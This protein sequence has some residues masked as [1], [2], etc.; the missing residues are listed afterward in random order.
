MEIRCK[1]LVLRFSDAFERL[2]KEQSPTEPGFTVGAWINEL[3]DSSRPP[4][5]PSPRE[6]LRSIPPPNSKGSTAFRRRYDLR[7]R[8][9]SGVRES[10]V[11]KS[12]SIQHSMNA[13]TPGSPV[14]RGRPRGRPRGRSRRDAPAG[15]RG[16]SSKTPTSSVVDVPPALVLRPTPTLIPLLQNDHLPDPQREAKLAFMTPAIRFLRHAEATEYGALP[17][18]VQ[19]LWADHMVPNLNRSDCIPD[20]LKD[21]FNTL[22]NTPRKSNLTLQPYHFNP[23]DMFSGPDLDLI[24]ATASDV[25]Y[26]ADRYRNKAPES[27]WIGAVVAPLLHLTRRLSQFQR[28]GEANPQALEVLDITTTEI[29]PPSLCP[30]SEDLTLFKDLD[31][32]IDYAIGLRLSTQEQRLLERGVFAAENTIPSIN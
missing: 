29:S 18:L 17:Q 24:W 11:R 3:P 2:R 7:P 4:P 14:K 19:S 16:E 1:D 12:C 28:S 9:E 8:R 32:R 30:Y 13:D 20:G 10:G 31:K 25:M 21:R 6:P 22:L 5:R 23:T 26:M 15:T 27:H